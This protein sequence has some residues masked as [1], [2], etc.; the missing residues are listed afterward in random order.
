MTSQI[1]QSAIDAFVAGTLS[2]TLLPY[3]SDRGV[4]GECDLYVHQLGEFTVLICSERAD[5]PGASIT[6][7]A[8]APWE[9]AEDEVALTEK[10]LWLEHYGPGSD[11][12]ARHDFDHVT[13]ER[14]RNA[15]WRRV[16]SIP[17]TAAA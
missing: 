3:G 9:C 13:A 16:A 10:V 6:N 5:N 7:A 2:P 8:P 4:S 11:G 12:R 17:A 1:I 14:G 15:R